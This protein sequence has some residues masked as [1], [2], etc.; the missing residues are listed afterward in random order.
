MEIKTRPL[1]TGETFACSFKKAKDVFKNTKVVLNFAYTGRDYGA[2]ANTPS[3]SYL[4]R[5]IKGRV[6]AFMCLYP[7]KERGMLCFFVIKKHDFNE[8]LKLD[9]EENFL[10]LF[11]DF[12]KKLSSDLSLNTVSEVMLVE[13]I[14]GKLKL[15]QYK[16]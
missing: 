9:F 13:L 12:Y 8:P 6:I 5:N 14:G 4:K 3:A 10:P 15:H 2:F 1:N 11:Y 16:I 7:S